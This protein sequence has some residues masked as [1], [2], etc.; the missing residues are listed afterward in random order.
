[1]RYL[2][3]GGAGFIGSHL[4]ERLLNLGNEVVVLDN[5]STGNETNLSGLN[6]K[7]QIIKSELLDKVK[8]EKYL[9][10]C[11]FVVHLAAAVGV[12]NI[13]NKPLQSL[14]TNLLN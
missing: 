3:T 11:D 7:V 2:V 4:C 8:T 12:L 10:D 14:K 6:G 5:F 9:K 13:V 1:M